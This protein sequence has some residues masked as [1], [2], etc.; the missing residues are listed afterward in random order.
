MWQSWYV[1]VRNKDSNLYTHFP[2]G[3][4]TSAREYYAPSNQ[5]PF[6]FHPR[7]YPTAI[8]HEPPFPMVTIYSRDA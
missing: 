3:S 2:A 7:S 8:R 1:V 4:S 5:P 6:S